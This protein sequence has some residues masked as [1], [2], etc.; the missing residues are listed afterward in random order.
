VDTDFGDQGWMPNTFS[1]TT[2]VQDL[3]LGQTSLANLP[4]IV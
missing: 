2:T 3:I 1:L 4:G